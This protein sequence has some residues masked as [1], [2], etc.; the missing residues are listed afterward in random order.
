[1]CRLLF[2]ISALLM[3]FTSAYARGLNRV[4]EELPLG[5]VKPDGWLR[6]M[7]QR[8]RDG[9]TAD[10]DMIYPQVVGERNGW[11]GG[12]GDQWERGPYWIDG[13]L[14]MAYILDDAQLKAKAQR[15]VEWALASQQESGQFGPVTDYPKESGIQRT[16]SEDW[17]PRMV[18]LKV[19]QQYYNATSD[20]RVLT[21]MDRY[22]RYQHRKRHLKMF[23][24]CCPRN[25]HNREHRLSLQTQHLQEALS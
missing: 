5:T 20:E 25:P 4:Y 6:E 13:L 22:F 7:L 19:L 3:T 8:Q 9:V 15:W 1:M 21:F 23:H 18:M 12:D 16:N 11:L 10:L 24:L 14:P 2:F 17:W